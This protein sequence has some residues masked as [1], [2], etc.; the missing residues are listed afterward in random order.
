MPLFK[1]LFGLARQ[2]EPPRHLVRKQLAESGRLVGFCPTHLRASAVMYEVV[3]SKPEI[4]VPGSRVE[5]HD[6]TE[7]SELFRLAVSRQAHD[8]VLVAELEEAEVL[9]NCRVIETQRMRERY[10]TFH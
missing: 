1:R 2:A 5:L 9:R 4:V 6:L 7:H 8:F 10:R 3:E